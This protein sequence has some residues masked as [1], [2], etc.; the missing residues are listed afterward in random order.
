MFLLLALAMVFSVIVF[1]IVY[2]AIYW[3]DTRAADVRK[4]VVFAFHLK[5]KPLLQ[6]L[7]TVVSLA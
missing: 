6:R 1:Q 3:L 2:I 5:G 4:V 7:L